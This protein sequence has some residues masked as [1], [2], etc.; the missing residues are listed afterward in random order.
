MMRE[1]SSFNNV[2]N[3]IK[4]LAYIIILGDI[5]SKIKTELEKNNNNMDLWKVTTAWDIPIYPNHH[6]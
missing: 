5:D 1:E 6:V 4:S 3:I 2:R